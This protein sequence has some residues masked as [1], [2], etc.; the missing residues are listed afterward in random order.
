MRL[1]ASGEVDHPD[2][3]RALTETERSL[4]G[5]MVEHAG[6]TLS[7]QELQ[8]EVWHYSSE[9]RSRTV[10]M[11]V[12]RVRRK[13]EVDPGQPR[14]LLTILGEGYRLELDSAPA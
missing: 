7:M 13:V 14:F 9:A 6:R 3:P 4:L 10:A 12:S 11:T 8:T 2:G 5:Y 1:V